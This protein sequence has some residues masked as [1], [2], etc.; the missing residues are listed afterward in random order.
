M[1][2]PVILTTLGI[3]PVT[4]YGLMLALGVGLGLLWMRAGSRRVGLPS[5]AAVRFGLWA[6]PLG[7]LGGRALYVALRWG[8]I[9]DELGWQ[10]LFRLWDGGFALFGV[11]PGCMLA[12]VCCAKTMRCPTADLLDAAAPGAALALAL[13][14]FAEFFTSQGIGMPVE[15]PWAQWFPLAMQDSYGEWLTP[16]FFWEGL[17]ALAVALLAANRLRKNHRRPWEAASVWLL[18]IGSTQVLLESM[19]TDDLL[20]L[21]LVKASQLAAMCCVLA[22]AIY[23]AVQA[24]RAHTGNAGLGWSWA[25][26]AVGAGLCVAIEFALD[27]SVIPNGVLYGLMALALCGMVIIIQRLHRIAVAEPA[28]ETQIS[29]G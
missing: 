25:G 4:V 26:L 18:G 7:L 12:A 10:Q 22:V 17:A 16:I 8:M 14:R 5:D 27:K 29:L 6:L 20:R 13:A 9:V 2:D 1:S 28:L 11:I 3:F 19:R 15:Q 21:G 24:K 23:W